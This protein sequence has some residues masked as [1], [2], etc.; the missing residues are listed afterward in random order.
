MSEGKKIV[1]EYEIPPRRAIYIGEMDDNGE[2]D[3]E[4]ANLLSLFTPPHRLRK[5]TRTPT[6]TH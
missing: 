6:P 1:V 5:C 3:E 4:I 2:T